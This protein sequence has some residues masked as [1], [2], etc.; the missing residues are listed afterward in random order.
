MVSKS[1]IY[2]TESYQKAADTNNVTLK[3]DP[4]P[5]GKVCAVTFIA[6]KDE[7]TAGKT[8]RIGYERNGTNYWVREEPATT[9]YHGIAETG[10]MYLTENERPIGMV[11]T[12]TAADEIRLFVRGIYL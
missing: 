10:T 1:D 6:I 2:M 9:N 12:P 3:G 7:T 11:E 4:I 8:C 5:A